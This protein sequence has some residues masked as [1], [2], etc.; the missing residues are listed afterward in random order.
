WVKYG[1]DEVFADTLIEVLGT[2]RYL[3]RFYAL[4][5]DP[6]QGMLQLHVAYYTDLAG[7]APHVPEVCWEN[8]GLISVRD[9][10]EMPLNLALDGTSTDIENR[11]TGMP[12]QTIQR[13]DPVTGDRLDLPLPIGDYTIRTTIFTSPEDPSLQNFGGYF[14]VANGRT[15]PSAMAVENVAFDLT[16]EYAYY[17]K[18]QL[19]ATMSSMSERDDEGNLKRFEGF[20]TDFLES[21]IPEMTEVLPDWR[22][23]E[24]RTDSDA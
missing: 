16:S 2:S 14:F 21:L 17:C 18:I 8:H 11:A 5:G 12:Y 7:T 23:Y 1:E 6:A 24:G 4:N 9:P 15:T 13:T 3:Q 10:F 19:N 22:E 20:A